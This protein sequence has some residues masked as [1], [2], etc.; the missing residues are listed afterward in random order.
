MLR[1][2]PNFFTF[3]WQMWVFQEKVIIFL[4]LCAE[5]PSWVRELNGEYCLEPSSPDTMVPLL[6]RCSLNPDAEQNMH[7]WT[8]LFNNSEKCK[9]NWKSKIFYPVS[10]AFFKKMTQYLKIF[11]NRYSNKKNSNFRKY[12]NLVGWQKTK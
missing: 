7:A 6:F 5:F 10:I 11:L 4:E 12:H 3:S 9:K 1:N 2:F 8:L